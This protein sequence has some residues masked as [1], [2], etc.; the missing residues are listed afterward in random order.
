[1]QTKNSYTLLEILLVLT[2]LSIMWVAF[3]VYM[4]HDFVR[5]KVELPTA[6]NCMT[7]LVRSR[8]AAMYFGANHMITTVDGKLCVLAYNPSIRAYEPAYFVREEVE[9]INR[10]G[11]FFLDGFVLLQYDGFIS[12]DSEL[13][14]IQKDNTTNILNITVFGHFEIRE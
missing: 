9:S 8:Y 5:P 13:Q 1:M 12:H 11:E 14:I 2:L 10:Q 6:Q 3:V 7:L 4:V